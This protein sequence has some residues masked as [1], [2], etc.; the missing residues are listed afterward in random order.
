[1]ANPTTKESLAQGGEE[2]HHYIEGALDA[3][4]LSRQQ[5]VPFIRAMTKILDKNAKDAQTS[6]PKTRSTPKAQ[7]EQKTRKALLD[8]ERTVHCLRMN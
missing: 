3:P 8:V 4:R 1:M 7:E 6:Q 2:R 5:Q